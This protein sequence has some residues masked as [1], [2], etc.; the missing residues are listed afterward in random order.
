MQGIPKHGRIPAIREQV[1]L[2]RV[3]HIE[4]Y[5][6]TVEHVSFYRASTLSQT[7]YEHAI[8]REK[9][10]LLRVYASTYPDILYPPLRNHPRVIGRAAWE[11]C[12][13]EVTYQS[14]PR[15]CCECR[16]D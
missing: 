9:S 16:T 10:L 15:H 5:R 14:F 13:L 2:S 1:E 4:N 12:L 3:A 7:G 6:V 11:E 8:S